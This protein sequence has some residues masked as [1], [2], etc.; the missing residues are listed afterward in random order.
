M[1]KKTQ[2]NFYSIASGKRIFIYAI[3]FGK[4]F[5]AKIMNEACMAEK[6]IEENF[7]KCASFLIFIHKVIILHFN[8]VPQS[9]QTPGCQGNINIH[10]FLELAVS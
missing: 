8:I 5:A 3:Y 6:N 9:L 4:I 1:Q 7:K 10:F 2:H